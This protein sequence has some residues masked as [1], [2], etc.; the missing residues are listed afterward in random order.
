MLM[1][2]MSFKVHE[3]DKNV[4]NNFCNVEDFNTSIID[5]IQKINA[6]EVNRMLYIYYTSIKENKGIRNLNYNIN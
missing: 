3:S 1:C 4:R 2:L 5:K 6:P